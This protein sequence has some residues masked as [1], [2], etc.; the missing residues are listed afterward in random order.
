MQ[1]SSILVIHTYSLQFSLFVAR[2]RK[3]YNKQ[4]KMKELVKAVKNTDSQLTC[5]VIL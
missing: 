5:T 1:I 3:C 4:E 2:Q